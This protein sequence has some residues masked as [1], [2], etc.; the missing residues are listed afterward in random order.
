MESRSGSSGSGCNRA[1]GER[2]GA[3]LQ[4][5]FRH[6]RRWRCGGNRGRSDDGGNDRWSDDRCGN[7]WRKHRRWRG[8]WICLSDGFLSDWTESL[9]HRL[10]CREN[11]R[12]RDG[13]C[14]DY[15]RLR[16]GL[17]NK[18]WFWRWWNDR[19][20]S[21]RSDF[22][23]QGLGLGAD[24]C[25]HC[26]GDGGGNDRRCRGRCRSGAG[27]QQTRTSR[28]DCDRGNRF[29]RDRCWGGEVS[30]RSG[31][32]QGNFVRYRSGRHDGFCCGTGND[33]S[34]TCRCR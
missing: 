17:G 3:Y 18:S 14:G 30:D 2:R 29:S 16:L 25:R 6:Y 31:L 10:G 8:G 34:R 24:C 9:W 20:W 12:L 11:R 1:G 7:G 21:G 27:D 33:E 15:H 4:R 5:G 22:L 26:H 23:D 13:T 32:R 19:D 28:S